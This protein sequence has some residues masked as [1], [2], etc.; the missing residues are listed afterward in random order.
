MPG[1][2]R[3]GVEHRARGL[4]VTGRRGRE[5]V[6]SGEA[7]VRGQHL[8]GLPDVRGAPVAV[9]EAGQTDEGV[10]RRAGGDRRGRVE[11]ERR[12]GV[13]VALELRPAR[14]AVRPRDHELRVCQGESRGGRVAPRMKLPDARQRFGVAGAHGFEV[15]ARLLS[16]VLERR[17]FGKRLD[18]HG[19]PPL[20]HGAGTCL[21]S[22]APGEEVRGLVF[23]D[24][25]AG[26][27]LSADRKRPVRS[28]QTLAEQ[29]RIRVSLNPPPRNP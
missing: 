17:V 18:R 21:R 7:R 13:H 29:A 9:V 11:S 19:G 4:H 1:E 6:R 8:A 5:D 3:V 24:I 22:A 2:P 14:E 27:A 10:G 20:P 26:L 15:A 28:D 16:Q 12:D 25:R 23:S